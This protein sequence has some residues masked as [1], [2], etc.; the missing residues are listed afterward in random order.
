MKTFLALTMA[1]V[2]G[3]HAATYTSEW[4]A[5]NPGHGQSQNTNLVH[6]GAFSAWL[7]QPLLS[8]D[9]SLQ[10]GPPSMPLVEPAPAAPVLSI[11]R[12]GNQIR[13]SWPAATGITIE[14]TS[15]LAHDSAWTTVPG[16]YST[17]GAEQFIL[18]PVSTTSQFYR[19]A[20]P[21]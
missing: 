7:S 3:L 11:V 19:L 15:D 8:A 14:E 13:V 9:Y 16:P 21:D 2:A 6:A 18:V 1:C 4:S 10:T 17:D 12:I 20:F 5:F